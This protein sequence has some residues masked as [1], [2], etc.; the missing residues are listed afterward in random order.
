MPTPR[1]THHAVDR[2]VQRLH[3]RRAL[4]PRYLED[5]TNESIAVPRRIMAALLRKPIPPRRKGAEK[6]RCFGSIV[7]V[8]RGN[9]LVTVWKLGEEAL[10][11]LLL[12][13]AWRLPPG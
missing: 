5:I 8:I 12:W 13:I 3:I 2:A 6:Y 10:A 7:L 9:A 4:A 11:E 1:V